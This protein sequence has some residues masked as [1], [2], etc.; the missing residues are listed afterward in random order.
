M[1]RQPH[2]LP[3][4]PRIPNHF[5]LLIVSD[6]NTAVSKQVR[7]SRHITTCF[8]QPIPVDTSMK[9]HGIIFKSQLF[10]RIP[11]L[12]RCKVQE[13]HKFEG[14]KHVVSSINEREALKALTDLYMDMS[15]LVNVQQCKIKSFKK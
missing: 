3:E 15:N 5:L 13:D 2:Y 14:V 8:G 1:K 9:R 4:L 10:A 6:V 11:D 7:C 12:V